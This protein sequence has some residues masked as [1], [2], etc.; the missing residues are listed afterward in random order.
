MIDS[1]TWQRA[2]A[3][4]ALDLQLFEVMHGGTQLEFVVHPHVHVEVWLGLVEF[5]ARITDDVEDDRLRSPM[6]LQN[7]GLRVVLDVVGRRVRRDRA[8]CG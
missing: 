3:A 8:S 7:V 5:N 1:L 4:A 2:I 6:T